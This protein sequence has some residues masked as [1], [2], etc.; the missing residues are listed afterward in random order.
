MS[1]SQLLPLTLG[2]PS[3]TGASALELRL[4]HPHHLSGDA[5]GL[6][7]EAIIGGTMRSL[8]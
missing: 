8:A 5:V 2:A 7:L 6:L 3:A 4:R 1:L